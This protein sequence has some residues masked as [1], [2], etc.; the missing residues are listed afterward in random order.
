M[1]ISQTTHTSCP[2]DNAPMDI[3]VRDFDITGILDSLFKEEA[4]TE[5]PP[6]IHNYREDLLSLLMKMKL[7]FSLRI[8]SAKTPRQTLN[9]PSA[10]GENGGRSETDFQIVLEMLSLNCQKWT[11]HAWISGYRDS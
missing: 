3:A 9:G 4:M 2:D 7:N 1:S 5:V 6:K 10:C 11:R 8:M